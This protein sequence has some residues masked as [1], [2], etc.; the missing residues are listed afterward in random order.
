MTRTKI[1]LALAVCLTWSATAVAESLTESSLA[2]SLETKIGKLADAVR[3][4]RTEI[5][6]F[7]QEHYPS[8]RA[9]QAEPYG[10][11]LHGLIAHDWAETPEAWS[12]MYEMGERIIAETVTT[13][14]LAEHPRRPTRCSRKREKAD[15]RA[16]SCDHSS[17][18]APNST[19]APRGGQ[20]DRTWPDSSSKRPEFAARRTAR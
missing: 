5:E 17:R 10:W 7:R 14:H 15:G 16:F 4:A 1:A 12:K 18:R 19:D 11:C 13:V 8:S 9:T 2:A 3:R 20:N 6:D